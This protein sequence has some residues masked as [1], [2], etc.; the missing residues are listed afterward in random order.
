MKYAVLYAKRYVVK[1]SYLGSSMHCVF[2]KFKH[3]PRD[4]GTYLEITDQA[5][6]TKPRVLHSYSHA[7]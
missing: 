4:N 3:I 1:Y 5:R 2:S 6:C 7:Q